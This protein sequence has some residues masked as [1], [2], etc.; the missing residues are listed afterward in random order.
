[1]DR[2]GTLKDL[3]VTFRDRPAVK[4][5]KDTADIVFGLLVAV[6]LLILGYATGW[7]ILAYSEVV[8]VAILVIWLTADMLFENFVDAVIE[9]WLKGMTLVGT[10]AQPEYSY[11]ILGVYIVI[12]LAFN[13]QQKHF[14][15]GAIRLIGRLAT[16]LAGLVRR[17]ISSFLEMLDRKRQR[18]S[19]LRNGAPEGDE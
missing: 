3:F 1:M 7:K 11:G 8:T 16:F 15:E 18:L 5:N 13:L 19:D 4:E 12:H 14:W 2:F 17:L 6:A 10:F 9:L